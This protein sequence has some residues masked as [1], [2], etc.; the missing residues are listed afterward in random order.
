MI[1]LYTL[2]ANVLFFSKV[3]GI[4]SVAQMVLSD[5]KFGTFFSVNFSWGVGVM[6]GCYWG[7]G[8]SGESRT[9]LS[10]RQWKGKG[11]GQGGRGDSSRILGLNPITFRKVTVSNNLELAVCV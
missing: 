5:W 9:S 4:G 1:L 3:F 6:L 8:V 10:T 7:G 11:W 2:I